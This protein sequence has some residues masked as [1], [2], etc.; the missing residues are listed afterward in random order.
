M[1]KHPLCG[2]ANKKPV[3][4][5]QPITE[6]Y[7]ETALPKIIIVGAS[8]GGLLLAII[9]EKANIPYRIFERAVVYKPLQSAVYFNFQTAKIFQQLGLFDEIMV[10]GRPT[11]SLQIINE[12]REVIHNW[13]YR[14]APKLFG[15][16][17]YVLPKPNLY[18]ILLRHVPKSKIFNGVK[19]LSISSGDHFVTVTQENGN[20]AVCDILVG[21][22]GTYSA[23]RQNI[24]DKMRRA[25]LMDPRDL[26]PMDYST[27]CLIGQTRPLTDIEFPNMQLDDAQFVR[28]LG[29]NK[30]YSLTYFTTRQRKVCWSVTEYLDTST[31]EE[32]NPFRISE[33]DQGQVDRMCEKVKDIPII[34]GGYRRPV[35]NHL[36]ELS[37]RTRIKK[38]V[39]EEMHY[40]RTVLI[41]NACHK[42]SPSAGSGA[43]NSVLDAVV[44]GNWI[45]SLP[46]FSVLDDVTYAFR[47]YQDERMPWIK[48]SFELSKFFKEMLERTLKAQL[49]RYVSEYGTKFLTRRNLVKIGRNQPQQYFLDHIEDKG[50][51]KS[52][53][54]N[55]L[56]ECP[57]R[58]VAWKVKE[59]AKRKAAE[60]AAAAAGGGGGE[61]VAVVAV[62]ASSSTAASSTVA[63][64]ASRKV[65]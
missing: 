25:K 36:V 1:E 45:V 4:N 8:I 5:R 38:I 16:V 17:R 29:R 6:E 30:P 20:T 48:A 59:E 12:D 47:S 3:R 54:Q 24:F 32:N 44:L 37:D 19:I 14:E 60:E 33:W 50:S 55:S 34:A 62:S 64:A 52:A 57:A 40:L 61:S 15:S 65:A 2:H 31:R 9:L 46:P 21:A 13:D 58:V 10:A 7:V 49:V 26:E 43:T 23:V 28:V 51:R 39:M 22:D 41:G 53:F 35:V 63:L 18:R 56:V 42:L 27:V 11:N